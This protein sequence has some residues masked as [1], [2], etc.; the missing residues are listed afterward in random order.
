LLINGIVSINTLDPST[1][2]ACIVYSNMTSGEIKNFYLNGSY[3]LSCSNYSGLLFG[4]LYFDNII[5]NSYSNIYVSHSTQSNIPGIT[6]IMAADFNTN[7]SI[8]IIGN[9]FL[10][11]M[12]SSLVV[13]INNQKNINQI[14][15]NSN[16]TFYTSAIN[17]PYYSGIL[18]SRSDTTL[19]NISKLNIET[20]NIF[21]DFNSNVDNIT[22]KYN[23]I[24]NNDSNLTINKPEFCNKNKVDNILTALSSYT[25]DNY[26]IHSNNPDENIFNVQ[27]KYS[28]NSINIKDKSKNNLIE[29]IKNLDVYNIDFNPG[30]T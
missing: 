7:T 13:N 11:Y 24:Y 8:N 30:F 28:Y 14:N 16:V 18:A 25:Y 19:I 23:L 22:G 3:F 27:M 12:W 9:Y 2:M 29:F 26:G 6:L 15:F 17:S 1:G 21:T 5:I 10:N 4:N 20:N